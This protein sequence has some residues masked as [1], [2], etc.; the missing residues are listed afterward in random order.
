MDVLCWNDWTIYLSDAHSCSNRV[1][2]L[3]QLLHTILKL[4]FLMWLCLKRLRRCV[5]N[6]ITRISVRFFVSSFAFKRSPYNIHNIRK[7]DTVHKQ[8]EYILNLDRSIDLG[9]Q[10]FHTLFLFVDLFYILI[11]AQVFYVK[12]V[13]QF[14]HLCYVYTRDLVFAHAIW[15]CLKSCHHN[16]TQFAH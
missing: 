7:S 1:I 11:G 3:K 9:A 8:N 16:H 6:G 2:A 4:R 14:V 12:F 15:M 13:W 10:K 5:I